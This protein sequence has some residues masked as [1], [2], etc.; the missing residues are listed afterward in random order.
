MRTITIVGFLLVLLFAPVN[1][2]GGLLCQCEPVKVEKHSCCGETQAE[3]EHCNFCSCDMAHGMAQGVLA[4]G[5]VGAAMVVRTT[6]CVGPSERF[7]NISTPP[8]TTPPKFRV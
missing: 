8:L 4:D 6:A 2:A 5:R 1:A 3:P 7:E